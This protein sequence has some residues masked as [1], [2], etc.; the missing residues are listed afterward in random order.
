MGKSNF[1]VWAD[2]KQQ[3]KLDE[4]ATLKDAIDVIRTFA[5]TMSDV[6]IRG[7]KILIQRLFDMTDGEVDRL[8]NGYEYWI[9]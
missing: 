3:E 9:C 6:T 2:W 5:P 4:T 1:E 7:M 8:I